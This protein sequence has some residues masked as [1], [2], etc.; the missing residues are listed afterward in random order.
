MYCCIPGEKI[1][2]GTKLLL[3]I[4]IQENFRNQ[5]DL[6]LLIHWKCTSQLQDIAYFNYKFSKIK[7]K[8]LRPTGKKIKQYIKAKALDWQS[9]IQKHY[10]KQSKNRQALYKHSMK[11]IMNQGLYIQQIAQVSRLLH[12]HIY[13]FSTYKILGNSVTIALFEK[14]T[15]IN[16]AKL[17]IHPQIIS[18]PSCFWQRLR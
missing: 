16:I 18:S 8:S 9:D 7:I 4:I 11:L 5:K 6:C 10:K 14:S 13:S 15:R 3:K 1:I 17:F 2:N 12:T